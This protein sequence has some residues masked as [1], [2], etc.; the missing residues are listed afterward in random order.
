[1][2][3]AAATHASSLIAGDRSAFYKRLESAAFHQFSSSPHRDP[4]ALC[5]NIAALIYHRF[6]EEFGGINGSSVNWSGFY[7][8]RHIEPDESNIDP[9]A[10]VGSAAAEIPTSALVLGPFHGQPAVSLIRRGKGV[11]GTAASTCEI[12]LVPDVHLFP[13]HIA[14]DSKSQSELVI[15]I[16]A[17][18]NTDAAESTNATVIPASAEYSI[19]SSSSSSS[20]HRRLVGVLD[21]DS[22]IL[23]FYSQQ[24]ADS[25]GKIIEKLGQFA[26]WT[27]LEQ[28]IKVKFPKDTTCALSGGKKNH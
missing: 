27:I 8:L 26:D 18:Y 13:G 17:N 1:M 2:S 7:L 24:D 15:P 3:T 14:C 20:S 16:F 11:C 28:T 23:N 4:I 12:Q 19:S 5:A 10:E 6:H 25:L 9:E 21:L 22:P